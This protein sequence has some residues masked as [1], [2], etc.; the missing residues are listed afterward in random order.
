[1]TSNLTV[2]ANMEV[3]VSKAGERVAPRETA[4]VDSVFLG[5]VNGKEGH[6]L[7]QQCYTHFEA[8]P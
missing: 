4:R 2:D 7:T 1:M 5:D 8:N 3:T 6:R